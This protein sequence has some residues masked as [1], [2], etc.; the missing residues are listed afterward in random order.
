MAGGRNVVVFGADLA[1]QALAA[2]LVGE[3]VVHTAPVLL[4]KG[5]R[6][7][8]DERVELEPV[9]LGSTGPM[10]DLHYRVMRAP[11]AKTVDHT[12]VHGMAP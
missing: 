6:L 4:G 2:G 9:H 7:A 1:R 5:I 3:I 10:A 11:R 8:V 12:G